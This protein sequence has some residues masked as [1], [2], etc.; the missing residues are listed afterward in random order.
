MAVCKEE[1]YKKDQCFRL[2]PKNNQ[3]KYSRSN[4]AEYTISKSLKV[5][6]Y[7]KVTSAKKMVASE[8]VVRKAQFKYFFISCEI[9]APF[10]KYL[11]L[12]IT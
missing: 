2:N 12:H 11:N 9:H 5:P 1:Q 4:F 10:L 8:N 6:N 7:L 3:R